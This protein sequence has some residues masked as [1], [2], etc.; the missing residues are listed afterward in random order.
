LLELGV[1][2]DYVLSA[3]E[4]N[5]VSD[6]AEK[7][8]RRNEPTDLSLNALARY[9]MD[10]SKLKSAY[11]VSLRALSYA[12]E[13][14]EA[15]LL[16]A[17][18]LARLGRMD[19]A[20][21]HGLRAIELSPENPYFVDIVADSLVRGERFEL[22]EQLLKDGLERFGRLDVLVSALRKLHDHKRNK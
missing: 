16:H 11:T 8:S 12:P 3:L 2:S 20:V 17:Q 10:R 14:G 18:I 19:E 21:Q 4:H 9:L 22:A 1:L 15:H 7:I 13:W 5:D 6:V